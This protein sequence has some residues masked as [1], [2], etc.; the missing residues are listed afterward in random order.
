ML[1]DGWKHYLLTGQLLP[2]CGGADEDPPANEDPPVG[3][4]DDK[5][6]PENAR[7][8][9]AVERAARETAERDAKTHAKTIAKLQ[10]DMKKL[11]DAHAS[12]DDKKISAARE[13]AAK[14]ERA[15]LGRRIIEAA[16]LAE[17]AGKISKPGLAVKLLA[18]DL[19]VD[20]DGDVDEAAVK[21]AVEG[22]LKENPELAVVARGAGKSGADTNAGRKDD[23]KPD[24]DR[25]LRA[26]AG[27][28]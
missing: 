7:K 20:D 2:I 1:H 16:V 19:T 25:L 23:G 5:D 21:A 12:D 10:A 8:A 6:L 11:S 14:E 17:A 13:E 27:R 22:F 24:M 9:L 18:A 28:G 15:K 4:G 3:Q 26:A